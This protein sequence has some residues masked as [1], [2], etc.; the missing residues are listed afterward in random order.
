MALSRDKK[1]K[2]RSLRNV[3]HNSQKQLATKENVTRGHILYYFVGSY[4]EKP[5]HLATPPMQ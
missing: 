2:N 4:V 5:I 1:K 3:K